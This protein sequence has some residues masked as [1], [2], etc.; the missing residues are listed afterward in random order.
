MHNSSHCYKLETQSYVDTSR[1]ATEKQFGYFPTEQE[2][3]RA[4]NG[5]VKWETTIRS[6]VIAPNSQTVVHSATGTFQ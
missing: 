4:C 2:A 6:R 5:I 1:Q 3:I